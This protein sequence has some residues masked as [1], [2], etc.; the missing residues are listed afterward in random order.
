MSTKSYTPY[1]N[2]NSYHKFFVN[3]ANPLKIGIVLALKDKEMNV[4]EITKELQIEQSKVSHAL[5]NLKDCNIVKSS[6]KGKERIYSLNKKTI[7]PI[8]DIINKHAYEFCK[9]KSCMTKGCKKRK[10]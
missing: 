1:L 3:L 4:T 5:A 2:H 7:V 8:L 9:C 6:Q 10:K